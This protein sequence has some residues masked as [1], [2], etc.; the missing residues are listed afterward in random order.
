MPRELGLRVPSLLTWL[1]CLFLRAAI[2]RGTESE[3][4]PGRRDVQPSGHCPL[5]CDSHTA[6]QARGRGAVASLRRAWASTLTEFNDDTMKMH[7]GLDLAESAILE[8]I[9]VLLRQLECRERWAHSHVAE[10]QL[11]IAD[12]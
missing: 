6:G 11:Q 3:R 9:Q 2:P 8:E 12:A 1:V 4:P 7:V 10:V 5:S